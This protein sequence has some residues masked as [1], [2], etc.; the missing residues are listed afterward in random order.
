MFALAGKKLASF[1]DI[2]SV[3]MV[4]ARRW[5]LTT[6]ASVNGDISVNSQPI[7]HIFHGYHH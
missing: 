6:N 7:R 3:T 1:S 4:W 5:V 2:G